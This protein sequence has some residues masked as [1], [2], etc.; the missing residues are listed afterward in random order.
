MIW[1]AE[2]DQALP[3]KET[4]CKVQGLSCAYRVAK[5]IGKEWNRKAR[6][7]PAEGCSLR[8]LCSIFLLHLAQLIYKTCQVF[9]CG[10]SG[11][12]VLPLHS[13]TREAAVQRSLCAFLSGRQ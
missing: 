4:L 12:F 9:I 2:E 13:G 1:V 3:R 5:D 11:G 6:A 10:V 7:G 8:A